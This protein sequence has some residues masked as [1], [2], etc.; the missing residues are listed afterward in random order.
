ML[1]HD[2]MKLGAKN[3]EM[4]L[5]LFLFLATAGL[6]GVSATAAPPGGIVGSDWPRVRH[7]SQLTGLSPLKGG[8]GRVPRE[9]WSVDLGGPMVASET[10]RTED[11]NGDGKTELLRIRKDGLICQDLRGRK[12]WEVG[13]LTGRPR[14]WTAP[15]TAGQEP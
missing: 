12:L 3:P 8:L 13:G 5:D 1:T 7:D 15:G 2:G 4:K 9:K 10:V 14:P 11:V 6:C